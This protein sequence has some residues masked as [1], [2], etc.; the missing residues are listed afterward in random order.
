MNHDKKDEYKEDAKKITGHEILGLD[1]FIPGV[2]H[3]IIFEVLSDHLGDEIGTLMR[4]FLNDTGY[5]RALQDER[6][7]NIRIL[8]HLKVIGGHLI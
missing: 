8:E 6:E 2:K 7:G 4:L 3:M 1:R 5:Q